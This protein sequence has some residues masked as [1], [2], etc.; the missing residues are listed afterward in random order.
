MIG[1]ILLILYVVSELTLS[2]VY[3]ANDKKIV[4]GNKHPIKTLFSLLI[5][6]LIWFSIF[7]F[8]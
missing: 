3:W 7:Y 5:N 6:G 2:L 1:K 8:W 4:L